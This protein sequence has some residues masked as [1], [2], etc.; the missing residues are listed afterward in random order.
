[1]SNL[2]ERIGAERL[3]AVIADFYDRVFDDVMIGFHFWGKDKARLVDKEW[4]FAARLL[5]GDVPYTGR[6]IR[7]A[8]AKLPIL[9]GQF[10]RRLQILR[11]TLADHGVAEEVRRAWIDHTLKLRPLVTADPTSDCDPELA[12]RRIAAG[13]ADEGGGG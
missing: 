5:G 7:E 2:F 13:E 9:G 6:P 1:M 4:E 8:H 12:A 3:R 10:D 11:E